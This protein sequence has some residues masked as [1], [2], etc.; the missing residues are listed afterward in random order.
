MSIAFNQG[1]TNRAKSKTQSRH[2]YR[3]HLSGEKLKNVGALNNTW[4]HR[5]DCKTRRTLLS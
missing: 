3:K 4:V 5:K 2:L 1:E